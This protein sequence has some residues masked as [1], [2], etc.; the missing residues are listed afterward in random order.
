MVISAG[1]GASLRRQRGTRHAFVNSANQSR[2]CAHHR[3][4]RTDPHGR[5]GAVG[6]HRMH[7]PAARERHHRPWCRARDCDCRLGGLLGLR[8][9]LLPR[10]R[11]WLLRA[12]LLGPGFVGAALLVLADLSHTADRKQHGDRVSIRTCRYMHARTSGHLRHGNAS[13]NQPGTEDRRTRTHALA[14]MARP[15]LKLDARLGMCRVIFRE[16]GY[17]GGPEPAALL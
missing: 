7:K 5:R 14:H 11:R 8:H 17:V 13:G 15:H 12:R 1:G 2:K 3:P 10:A 6:S 4:T 16:L 9:C